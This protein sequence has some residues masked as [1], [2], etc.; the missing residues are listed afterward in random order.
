MSKW[1]R[2]KL[3]RV[4]N[5][6]KSGAANT[7]IVRTF[8]RLSRVHTHFAILT[9][10]M[11]RYHVELECAKEHV[12]KSPIGQKA[13]MIMSIVAEVEH[14]KIIERTTTGR[15]NI[16]V[17]KNKIIPSWK[18]RFGYSYDNPER[19][20]TPRVLSNGEEAR[21]IQHMH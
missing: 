17:Q 3:E 21:G 12:D 4:R 5:L 18:P 8:D 6:Y 11:Q 20:M 15:R 2:K 14:T 1:E 7:V 16:V 10:E 9:E 19:A 13:R